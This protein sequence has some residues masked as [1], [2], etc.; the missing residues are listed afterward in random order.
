MHDVWEVTSTYDNEKK[1]LEFILANAFNCFYYEYNKQ[2]YEGH[3]YV[4]RIGLYI[5][6]NRVYGTITI[7]I[8]KGLAFVYQLV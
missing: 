1:Q 2:I 7:Y 4:R 6:K 5:Y 3:F 8:L